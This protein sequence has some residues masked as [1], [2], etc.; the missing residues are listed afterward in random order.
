MISHSTDF[1]KLKVWRKNIC[2][3][4]RFRKNIKEA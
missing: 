3:R 2:R 1:R 4:K